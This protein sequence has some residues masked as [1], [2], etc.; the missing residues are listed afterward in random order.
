MNQRSLESSFLCALCALLFNPLLSTTLDAAPPAKPNLVLVLADDLGYGDLA[1]YGAADVRTPH[2]DRFAAEGLRLTSCYAGH[3]NCSPS[4]TAL[5]T[6]RTPTRVGV[7]NWIPHGST[8]HLRKEEITIATLLRQAG[9]STCHAGKWHLTGQFNE[10]TQPQAGDH[11][12]D[13]WFGTQNNALPS[14][15]NPDNFVRNGKPVG[16]L[17][18][19]SSQIVVD[20]ATA[21][22]KTG[23]DKAKPFFL[24]VC[25]HEPHEPIASDEKYTKLYPHEDPAYSA[26][27]GNI[28]QM[29]AA[30]GR[31]MQ[32]L[33]DEGLAENTLVWFTSD[34]GPAITAQHPYGS[35]G[36]LRDKKGFVTEGGIRVPGIIR[37][38]GRIKP[39]GTSDEP[40]CGVDFL[41]TVCELAGLTPP[42]DRVLDGAS[43]TPVFSGG[44]VTRTE[45]LYWHFNRAAGEFHVALR[46]GDWK[47][48]AKLDKIPVRGNDI[49]EA[50]EE[51]FKAAKPVSFALYHLKD[52]IGEKKELSVSEPAKFAEMKELLIT[53]YH[54]VR[55]ESPIWPAWKFDN[56]EGQRIEWPE[57]VKQ[58]QAKGKKKGK[59]P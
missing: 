19:Y 28:T 20:E 2:L 25:F 49:T 12:F 16:K 44:S 46:Q 1:C 18:G 43:I 34:N 3:P 52:D 29:D 53:K 38:P 40:V 15:R 10:P 45:P 36:P 13:H 39:G 37:F 30:F 51:Q 27:H 4:R 57:Y 47:I 42:A 23:R 5:M 54:E 17:E 41:P 22:L 58:R 31:L 21:W 14:H 7:R 35:A 6:G 48:L 24:Y 8:V 55:D 11:G 33:A 50:D 32:V 56:R 26:H 59:Q 9:Y